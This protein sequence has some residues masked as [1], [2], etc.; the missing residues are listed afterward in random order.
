MAETGKIIAWIVGI[1]IALGVIGIGIFFII[2]LTRADIGEPCGFDF[3]ECKSELSCNPTGLNSA[4]GNMVGSCI[5]GSN[6]RE[7]L[8]SCGSTFI[9]CCGEGLVCVEAGSPTEGGCVS[10]L[11]F[12]DIEINEKPCFS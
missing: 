3:G 4:T 2:D 7:S 10:S 11:G 1:I 6:D 5:T 9:G 12:A 8:E